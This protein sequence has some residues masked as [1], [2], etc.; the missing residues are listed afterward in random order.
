MSFIDMPRL[1]WCS[2]L[3][4]LGCFQIGCVHAQNSSGSS[5]TIFSLGNQRPE[6]IHALPL[7]ANAVMG[8]PEGDHHVLVSDLSWGSIQ[9]VNV[10][11]GE[12][13]E[14]VESL[15]PGI[16]AAL[17]MWYDSGAILVSKF[18]FTCL[19]EDNVKASFS[20]TNSRST[21]LT[22]PPP[23]CQMAPVLCLV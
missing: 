9:T 1:G 23:L 16:R 3:L 19:Y 8:L 13:T 12:L 14:I 4:M 21:I 2:L 7:E 10:E 6:G 22:L 11:T 5:A 18:Y 17:G 20:N 15:G